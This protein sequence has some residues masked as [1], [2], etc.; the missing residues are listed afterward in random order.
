[1]L[2]KYYCNNCAAELKEIKEIGKYPV[3][4]GIADESLEETI[5][6]KRFPALLVECHKCSLIQQPIDEEIYNIVQSIYNNS[7]IET[8]NQFSQEGWGKRR[9]NFFKKNFS[10][11]KCP[12]NVLEIGCGN[13]FLLRDFYAKGSRVVVGFEPSFKLD[14]EFEQ[15]IKIYSKSFDENSVKNISIKFDLIYSNAVVEHIKDLKSHFNLIRKL[16]KQDGIFI[17]GVPNCEI[18]LQYG[19]FG[20]FA[21]EHINY[22]TEESLYNSLKSTGINIVKLIKA[23]QMLYFEARIKTDLDMTEYVSK[24]NEYNLDKFLKKQKKTLENLLKE[25]DEF[26]GKLGF[27]GAYLGLSNLLAQLNL[28]KEKYYVFDSDENKWDKKMAGI[29]RRVERLDNLTKFRLN[30]IVVVPLIFQNEISDLI[31]ENV[32]E[33]AI[34]KLYPDYKE[35]R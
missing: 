20:M 21:H 9:L 29:P 24:D 4:Y 11:R 31:K 19:D 17:C 34:I 27:Y 12:E 23:P 30:K 16:L 35:S 5:G 26:S 13:G 6:K 8:I 32:P 1:M 15:G 7:K 22:F 18:P 3:C 10:F 14:I 2:K 28:S 33:L 25:I